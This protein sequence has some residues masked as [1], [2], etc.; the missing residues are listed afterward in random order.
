M[1]KDG[2]GG[3]G[4]GEGGWWGFGGC[5]GDAGPERGAVTKGR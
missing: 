1:G 5:E 2:A 4:K 3:G